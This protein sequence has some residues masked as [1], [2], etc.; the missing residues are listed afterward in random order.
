MQANVLK[1]SAV[2]VA[3][4]GAFALGGVAADRVLPSAAFAAVVPTVNP[5]APTV[6][7]NGAPTVA[8]PDFSG[9]VE[10][11]GPAVVNISVTSDSRKVLGQDENDNAPDMQGASAVNF[12]SSSITSRCRGRVRR[13]AWARA[14]SS[15]PTAS[16]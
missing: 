15:T 2:A 9:L 4:A 12:A 7:V 16:C 5:A 8:L 13:A 14:S 3:I 6:A 1:R 10:Q 11:Y